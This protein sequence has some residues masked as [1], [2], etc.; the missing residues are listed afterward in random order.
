MVSEILEQKAK[1]GG[2]GGAADKVA[3]LRAAG[4]GALNSVAD[5]S[6]LLGEQAQGGCCS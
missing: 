5:S 4:V 1:E 6:Y 2:G 3:S